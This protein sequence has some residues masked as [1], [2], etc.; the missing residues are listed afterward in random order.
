M[1]LLEI[2]DD[3]PE[4]HI[5]LLR[6]FDCPSDRERAKEQRQDRC[7]ITRRKQAEAQKEEA[8]PEHHQ[9]Q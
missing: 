3:S 1:S 2:R 4:R 6:H 7:R 8:Q 9:H 5:Q